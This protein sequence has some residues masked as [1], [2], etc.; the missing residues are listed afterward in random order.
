MAE[1][2]FVL[3]PEDDI[4]QHVHLVLFRA[5]G[6]STNARVDVLLCG[7][8]DGSLKEANIMTARTVYM[9]RD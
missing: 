3:S 6:C 1:A 9:Y 5:L 7:N 2:R 8:S 4:N